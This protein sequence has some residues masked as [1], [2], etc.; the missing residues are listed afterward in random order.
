MGIAA[1]R[2]LH[3]AL[4]VF[5]DGEVL[6]FCLIQGQP[7]QLCHLLQECDVLELAVWQI[8]LRDMW[9]FCQEGKVCLFFG[10]VLDAE[11]FQSGKSCNGGKVR[12]RGIVP[13]IKIQGQ[14]FQIRQIGQILQR[15]QGAVS[16][17]LFQ[18][19]FFALMQLVQDRFL[20]ILAV[21]VRRIPYAVPESRILYQPGQGLFCA[22]FCT[23]FLCCLRRKWNVLQDCRLRRIPVCLSCLPGGWLAASGQ[24]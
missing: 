8:E 1:E 22:G 11:S 9:H 16:G 21:D 5:Q 24:E 23:V 20:G 12:N 2:Q 3:Q 10:M 4:Q 17:W 6:D 18:Y 7:F 14:A 19:Q 15:M 13:G